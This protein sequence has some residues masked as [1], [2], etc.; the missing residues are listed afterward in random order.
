[1]KK[2]L[3]CLK[4]LLAPQLVRYNIGLCQRCYYPD[5]VPILC[6]V[7][8]GKVDLVEDK[9]AILNHVP[10]LNL[11]TDTLV[12]KP[13]HFN[14]RFYRAG[15]Y[16][17]ACDYLVLTYDHTQRPHAVFIDL[18]TDIYDRPDPSTGEFS[19][20]SDRDAQCG[21]QFCGARALFK[22][23]ALM[24]KTLTNCQAFDT[25]KEHYWVLYKNF[26]NGRG[27]VGVAQTMIDGSSDAVKA[28]RKA[29]LPKPI[30]AREVKNNEQIDISCLL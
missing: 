29:S 5:M 20:S 2:E 11:G 24:V 27:V 21:L 4:E 9:K 8:G 18:K 19:T 3:K 25:Y 28:F 10:L 17:K 16:N 15:T 14:I 1:M 12:L 30:Y 23:L 22:L 13:D 6:D 7:L 26:L